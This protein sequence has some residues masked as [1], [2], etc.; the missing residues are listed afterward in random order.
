MPTRTSETAKSTDFGYAASTN[1][2]SRRLRAISAFE[3]DVS[4]P[5]DI[6][7]YKSAGPRLQHD[8]SLLKPLDK[9]GSFLASH[10]GVSIVEYGKKLWIS[11]AEERP[12]SRLTRSQARS[13]P[14][15]ENFSL[16]VISLW[17]CEINQCPT[18]SSS[19]IYDYV[20]FI[21]WSSTKVSERGRP[22]SKR[23][24]PL[25]YYSF[26]NRLIDARWA[27]INVPELGWPEIGF[28]Q[29]MNPSAVK[30]AHRTIVKDHYGDDLTWGDYKAG[31]S[32]DRLGLDN[33]Q[34]Y[35]AHCLQLVERYQRIALLFADL[36]D[37]V[38]KWSQTLETVDRRIFQNLSLILTGNGRISDRLRQ[39]SFRYL[40]RQVSCAIAKA[41]LPELASLDSISSVY[42]G[43]YIDSKTVLSPPRQ[44]V[45]LV[46]CAATVCFV[47]LS[48][49]R[50]SDLGFSLA[51]VEDL[52]NRDPLTQ[53]HLPKR[54]FVNW[55]VPKN[56]SG[57]IENRE[58]TESQMELLELLATLNRAG[59]NKP[60]FINHRQGKVPRSLNQCLETPWEDFVR[61]GEMPSDLKTRL[62][63]ELPLW[64]LKSKC[65]AIQSAIRRGN[66]KK[67]PEAER[68]L[69]ESIVDEET[70]SLLSAGDPVAQK[71][72]YGKIGE[73][74]TTAGILRPNP[75]SF[76]HMWAEAVL[77]RFDGDVGWMIRS[78][79]KHIGERFWRAYT[80]NK[81]TR[82]IAAVEQTAVVS[83]LLTKVI[84]QKGVE[85]AG[86]TVKAIRRLFARTHVLSTKFES[87]IEDFAA[88]EVEQY[89]ATP[90]GYCVLRNS[91]RRRARCAE[92][93]I[94]QPQNASD[95]LCLGCTNFLTSRHHADELLF[96]ANTHS[97]IVVNDAVPV[98][99]RL[100]SLRA[101]RSASGHLKTFGIK[102]PTNIKKAIAA[103]VEG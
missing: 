3:D 31:G 46:T 23:K 63:R 92:D 103:G 8:W 95:S 96:I 73:A 77:R 88:R 70:R 38:P 19:D 2:W 18:I 87:K 1:A 30:K 94:P 29:R 45:S 60:C 21:L 98:G 13:S 56:N 37:E 99:F 12:V 33:G 57:A 7:R 64:R 5:S 85:Y 89:K 16:I 25:G 67:R 93:G 26:R 54:Y 102:L 76:R 71:R 44:L 100:E 59:E 6:W 43:L 10:F 81:S 61:H 39:Q 51:D 55:Q 50:T 62:L 97:E 27:R 34:Y 79:F 72:L 35:V 40:E 11:M 80:F 65:L 22:F 90:W 58:I 68:Q 49:W 66:Y 75:Y 53:K 78:Q 4:F 69:L 52:P 32:L 17:F 14:P 24:A 41:D 101:M 47:A 74:C 86:P 20:E 28:T 9:Q 83:R 42:N 91:S 48:G 36:F 82:A 15:A 84:S